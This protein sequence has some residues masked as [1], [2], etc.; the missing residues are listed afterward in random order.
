MLYNNIYIQIS[1]TYYMV[2]N[3][4]IL[5]ETLINFYWRLLIILLSKAT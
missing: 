1:V 4:L 3:S 2:K 5:I